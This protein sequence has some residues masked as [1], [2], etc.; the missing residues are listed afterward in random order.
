VAPLVPGTDAKG[1]G[2]VRCALLET[3]DDEIAWVADRVAA[4]RGLVA[5]WDEVAVLCRTTAE[6][7]ALK[8]ALEARE[9]PVEVVGTAGLLALPEVVEI[10][11]VL[12]VL[13]DPTAN[14]AFVRL[15]TGPRWRIGP[16][17]L[18]A[19]GAYAEGLA[20]GRRPR[21]TAERRTLDEELDDAVVGA[22]PTELVSL[23]DAV[24]HLAA[25]VEISPQARERLS[26]LARQVRALRRHVGEPLVD[27]VH[28][29][30]AVT[31]LDVELSASPEML[32]LRRTEGLHAFVDLVAAFQDAEGASSIGAF[33]A[34]LRLAERYDKVPEL[35]RPPSSDAV[36]LMTVHKAKLVPRGR[37]AVPAATTSPQAHQGLW[38]SS[39][40]AV[41]H[42]ARDEPVPLA[43]RGFPPEEGPRA[44]DLT[45]LKDAWRDLHALE[46]IRLGYVAVTRAER[47]LLASASFWP[48]GVKTPRLPG[49]FL[50]AVRE[51]ALAGA[52]QVDE[53][54]DPPDDDAANPLREQA[55]AEVI[56]WP[57]PLDP[58]GV[59]ARREAAADVRAAQ[60]RLA[61]SGWSGSGDGDPLDEAWAVLGDERPAEQEW[62]ADLR[63]V[64]AALAADDAPEVLVPLP[65]SM[66]ASALLALAE[67]PEAFLADL[68]RPMPRRPSR[69]AGRGTRFHAWVE[70][71]FGQQPML[72]PDDLPGAADDELDDAADLADLQAGFERTPYADLTPY[73]VEAPFALV[74]A[75]RV[76]RGRIDAVYRHESLDPQGRPAVRWE[77]VDWKTGRGRARPIRCSWPPTG[78][79]AEQHA[80]GA[81]RR[82]SDVRPRRHEHGRAPRRPA[83]ARSSG[84]AQRFRWSCWYPRHE[85]SSV[86]LPMASPTRSSGRSSRCGTARTTCPCR[87]AC[88]WRGS[89]P[90]S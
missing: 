11:S 37:A 45:R 16:R 30:L 10:V 49:P 43:L 18:A 26:R 31:G 17:D 53:W 50:L 57:V 23:S 6:F 33:L 69:A 54:A 13:H 78:S 76:V 73:A 70:A 64:L 62:D 42:D 35:D 15:L 5:R 84:A 89:R 65:E 86:T 68:V 83:R 81:C 29:V 44:A 3:V 61:A 8:R 38:T 7:G 56:P 67:D 88:R 63:L 28:R 36:Q 19:L 32:A 72:D 58:A 14:P 22:D 27:L 46:E 82:G 90:R 20:S 79:P 52:G 21:G 77:V 24:L 34:W 9:V 85:L 74:L 4:Q 60:A 87:A 80:L 75:G 47:R 66:S 51:A 12:R 59:R 39:P 40:T 55:A 2:E 25:D 41:P 71:R 48:R 1:R